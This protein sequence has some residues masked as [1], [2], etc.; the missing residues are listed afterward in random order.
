MVTLEEARDWLRISG[1]DNDEI[2]SGLL[3]AAPDYIRVATGCETDEPLA[4][5]ITKF[6]LLLWYNAEQAEAER[7]QRTIDNLLKALA[8]KAREVL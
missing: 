6:L 3:A 1:T 8:V 7:L 2:I 5:T 4:D